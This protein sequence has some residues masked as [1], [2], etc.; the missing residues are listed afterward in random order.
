M[1]VQLIW[2]DNLV[3]DP[4]NG[5]EALVEYSNQLDWLQQ[6]AIELQAESE[7]LDAELQ[8]EFRAA[9]NQGN[10]QHASFEGDHTVGDTGHPQCART[11]A[12]IAGSAQA[13]W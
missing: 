11:S 2:L 6:Q 3:R 13:R 10:Y 5:S 8:P 7:L 4:R 1:G 9:I 12:V